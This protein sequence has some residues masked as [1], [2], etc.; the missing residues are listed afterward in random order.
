M[1]T[2]VSEPGPGKCPIC[3]MELV[4]RARGGKEIASRRSVVVGDSDGSY[5]EITS[6]LKPGELV[7]WAGFDGLV[8][9]TPVRSVKWGNGGPQTLPGVGPVPGTPSSMPGMSMD[10]TARPP[11][12]SSSAPVNKPARQLYTCPMH[13]EVVQDHPGKCPKCGM[14]LVPKKATK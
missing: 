14:D 10:G 9:G 8:E 2:E 11:A 1:H 4:P 13:P 12:N 7:I 6:G 3:K 5:T